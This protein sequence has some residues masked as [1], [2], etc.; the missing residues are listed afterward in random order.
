ML[1][2]GFPATLGTNCWVV[3]PG[4]GEQC[5]VIDPG[6]DATGPLEE[7]LAR[8]R[9]HPIAVLLTHGHY[10][11][12]WS[13]VPVCGARGIP[14][15]I[16]HHDRPQ[17][18]H[19]QE[20]MIGSGRVGGGRPFLGRRDFTEPDDVRE[21]VDGKVIDVGPVQLRISMAPG[22]TPGSVT[23]GIDGTADEPGELFSGDLIFAGSVG[24]T[25]LPGGNY[26]QLLNSLVRVCAPLA[27]ETRIR[28]GHGG[29]TTI[30]QERVANP[31]LRE[32]LAL[33][34]DA[35]PLPFT[36]APYRTS[37]RTGVR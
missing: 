21:L 25:D 5:V 19:P 20:A 28:P 14:A 15:Y 8:H 35:A 16:H 17:L 13:V 2:A 11:H 9:L 33:A 32:A 26:Q 1:V 12:T 23:F 22:H 36:T 27:D 24:R 31:F 10:D 4:P 37:S 29:V 3:A 7:Q 6:I 18:T 30:G 34:A